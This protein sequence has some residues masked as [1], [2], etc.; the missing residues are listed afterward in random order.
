MAE[1]LRITPKDN[2]AVA[3]SVIEKGAAAHVDGIVLTGGAA[4]LAGLP[5]AIYSALH[6]PCGVADDPQTS[7]VLGCGRALDDLNAYK[8]VLMDSRRGIRR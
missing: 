4:S 8:S 1:L 6:I 3:L 2:V 5:E 7:V